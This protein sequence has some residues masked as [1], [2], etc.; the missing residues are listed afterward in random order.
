[1]TNSL[2]DQLK[3]AE[4]ELDAATKKMAAFASKGEIDGEAMRALTQEVEDA[5]AKQLLL[6][7]QTQG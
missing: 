5:E 6:L 7:R 2:I 3:A 4:A 1:M